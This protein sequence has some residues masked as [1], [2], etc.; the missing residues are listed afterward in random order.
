[1]KV[2]VEDLIFSHKSSIHQ[3][4]DSVR[5]V[6]WGYPVQIA[7]AAK[8]CILRHVSWIKIG[9]EP[10]LHPKEPTELCDVGVATPFCDTKQLFS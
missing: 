8:I 5:L 6:T 2:L 7:D 3:T 4:P 10:G 1:M 9:L